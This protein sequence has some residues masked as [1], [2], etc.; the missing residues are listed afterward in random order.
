LNERHYGALQGKNKAETAAEH[1]D[2]QVKIWRRSF[3]VRPPDLPIDDPNSGID[4][5]YADLPRDVLPRAECL[6]DVLERMLPWWED[7]IV[8]DLRDG[9]TVLV[10]AHGNSLRALIMHLDRMTPEQVLELEFP[11]GEPLA[12]ELDDALTPEND[13]GPGGVKGRYLD[14]KRA[15]GDG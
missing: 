7:A 12:Y 10:A 9:N 14:S 5:R 1:G 2:K 8:P 15:L 4:E 13:V 6:R 3:D 11:T